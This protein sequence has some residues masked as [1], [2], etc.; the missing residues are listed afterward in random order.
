MLYDIV[1]CLNVHQYLVIVR[2]GATVGSGDELLMCSRLNRQLSFVN[3]RSG[4]NNARKGHNGST[5]GGQEIVGRSLWRRPSR[6]GLSGAGEVLLHHGR[7][8]SR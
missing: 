8:G 7:M 2:R 3:G 1:S 6:K 4:D 5:A